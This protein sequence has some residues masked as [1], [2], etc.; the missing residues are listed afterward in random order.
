MFDFI[1]NNPEYIFVF[2]LSLFLVFKIIR[3]VLNYDQ[4]DEDDQGNDGGIP[5]PDPILDL[6]PGVSLPLTPSKEKVSETLV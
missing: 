6:P 2:G 4:N 1:Q 3:A 5:D